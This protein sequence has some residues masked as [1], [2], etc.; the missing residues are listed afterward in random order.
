MTAL[1]MIENQAVAAAVPREVLTS[2]LGG[3]EYGMDILAVQEIRRFEPPTRIANAAGH[4]RGITNLRGV[5]VPIVDMRCLLDLPADHDLNTVTVIVN[6]A[7]RTVGLVV[8]GVSDVVALMPEQVQPRPRMPH[9]SHADFVSGV[10]TLGSGGQARLL[11][12]MNLHT[13]LQDL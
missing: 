4:L 9:R 1:S 11:Q 2:R 12:L 8:D 5:I 7:G 10:A 3:E 6:V 13:L